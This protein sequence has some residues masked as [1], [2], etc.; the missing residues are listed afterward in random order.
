MEAVAVAADT[1]VVV[2]VAVVAVVEVVDLQARTRRL[3]VA[4]VA[5]NISYGRGTDSHIQALSRRARFSYLQH[6]PRLVRPT[7]HYRSAWMAS[8]LRIRTRVGL[9]LFRFL[10]FCWHVNHVLWRGETRNCIN[11]RGLSLDSGR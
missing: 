3:W 8:S 9:V 1:V 5:G 7:A 4:I 6:T 11:R 2:V 10:F